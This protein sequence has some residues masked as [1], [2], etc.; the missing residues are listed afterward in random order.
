[1]LLWLASSAFIAAI[2]WVGL[3]RGMLEGAFAEHHGAITRALICLI[4]V[5]AGPV[6]V[7][8]IASILASKRR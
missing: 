2:V 4:F 5:A 7:M 8:A 1:M 6:S 3:R